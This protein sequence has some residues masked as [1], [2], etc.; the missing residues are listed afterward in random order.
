MAELTGPIAER[1]LQLPELHCSALSWFLDRAG[2]EQPWP[3][4]IQTAAGETLL[5]AR[6][7][8]INKHIHGDVTKEL[9]PFRQ[10]AVRS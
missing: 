3:A 4:P 10:R 6:P 5:G 9:V 8:G 1:L 7:K 2:S